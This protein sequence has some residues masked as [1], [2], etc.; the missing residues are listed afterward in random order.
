MSTFAR[1]RAY[2]VALCLAGSV[3]LV[4]GCS[5]AFYRRSADR[6]TY[7]A[8]G[9]YADE[10]RWPIASAGVNPP[11]ASRLYDPFNPDRPPLPPDDP[12]A[13][14]AMARP[15]GIRGSRT[16]HDDGDAPFIEAPDWLNTLGLNADGKL[17]LTPEKAVELGIRNSRDYQ[18]ALEA[19]YLNALALTLNRFDFACHWFLTN[20]TLWTAFGSSATDN[21]TL[22][23]ASTFGFTRN[24]YAGGQF[25][26]EVA[27]SFLFTFSGVDKAVVSTNLLATFTQPLLQGAGRRFRLEGLTEG[28]RGLLYA[29]R[30][31]AR[32]RKQFYV[33]LT[34]NQPNGYLSLLL[35]IQ[36]VRDQEAD[37]KSQEQNLRM[38][39]A[40]F[41]AQS[42][43][44]VQVDQALQSYLQSKLALIQAQTFL[45]TSLDNYKLTLGLPPHLPVVLD[46][47][48][49]KPFQLAAPELVTLQ[50]EADVFFAGYRERDQ[51]P[52]VE[53]LRAGFARLAGLETRATGFVDLV[54]SELESWRKLLG[55]ANEDAAQ[56][57]RERDNY[58]TLERLLPDLRRDFTDLRKGIAKDAGALGAAR[59]KEGWDAIQTRCRQLIA[60]LAQVFVVETQIRVYLIRLQP[61]PFGEKE[62][63]AYARANRLDLMNERG[64]VVDA[65]RQIAVTANAL[66]PGLTVTASANLTTN[67]GANNPVDFRS[68][69]STYTAGVQFD[70]PLN[71]QAERNAYRASQIAYEQERRIFMLL[72][73]SIEAAVRQDLRT[74]DQERVNFSIGRLALITAARQVEASRDRLLLVE[75]AADTTS[76]V[77]ILNALSAL[78]TAKSRLI[79]SWTNYQTARNQLFLDMEALQLNSQGVPVDEHDDGPE[80]LPTPRRDSAQPGNIHP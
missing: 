79:G 11:P 2:A 74:L 52:S 31:F 23:P 39:E 59:R 61:I 24:L 15:N 47:S 51:A 32:F 71:R 10:A 5:R 60:L 76:T 27:N 64:R 20:D 45:E 36:G 68:S 62:A 22:N 8:I 73:D 48:L 78:L 72:D 17:E 44:N 42:V 28:E 7:G 38:H 65:W 18:T 67:A 26:A 33:N 46:D 9:Q 34:T 3:I 25:L 4:S 12:T 13:A 80:T 40:L 57:G 41:E 14:R 50:G 16:F 49:L 75:R 53:D 29:V 30:V 69:A 19:L 54:A 56:S 21:E 63:C 66:R 43:S 58:Q 77:D 37:L 70:G 55:S 35:Q 6:E 1:G